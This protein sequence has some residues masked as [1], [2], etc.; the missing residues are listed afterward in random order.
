VENAIVLN[1]VNENDK[2]IKDLIS[3]GKKKEAITLKIENIEILKIQRI[4]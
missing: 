3:K 4:L 1:N 2:I